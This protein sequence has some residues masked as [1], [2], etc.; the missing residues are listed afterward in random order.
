M[1]LVTPVL[2]TALCKSSRIRHS[3]NSGTVRRFTA[4][5]TPCAK[6]PEFCKAEFWE[7]LPVSCFTNALCQNSRIR[8]SPNSGTV[9]RF[10]VLPTPCAKTAKSSAF[11]DCTPVFALECFS[12]NRTGNLSGFGSRFLV[13]QSYLGAK[14]PLDP[15]CLAIL[16]C[17]RRSD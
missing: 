5:P 17:N 9:C 6:T 14:V 15:L 12:A 8:H 4:L 3:P 1:H 13:R 11:C 10:P 7:S 2:P 16:F